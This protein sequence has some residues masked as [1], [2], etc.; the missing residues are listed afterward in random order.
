VD[1]FE[2]L[3]YTGALGAPDLASLRAWAQSLYPSLP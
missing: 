2:H 3:I 1:I